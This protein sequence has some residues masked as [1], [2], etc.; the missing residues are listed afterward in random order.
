MYIWQAWN[1]L[2][3]L[4]GLE[5]RETY[6]PLSPESA[7]IEGVCSHSSYFNFYFM[8]V[9]VFMSHVYRCLQ[10]PKKDA[11]SPRGGVG[12]SCELP[13]MDNGHRI[14]V[15]GRAPGNLDCSAPLQLSCQ[16]FSKIRTILPL[17]DLLSKQ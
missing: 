6:L 3:R 7:E 5:L 15:S 16:I 12:G 2:G 4:A 11:G 14:W 9:S 8:C 13:N 1:S 17:T 10:R